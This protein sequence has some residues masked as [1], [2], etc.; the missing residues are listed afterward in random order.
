VCNQD[1]VFE[2]SV[3]VK[4]VQQNPQIKQQLQQVVNRELEED[5]VSLSVKRFI[6]AYGKPH[7][8]TFRVF[9]PSKIR[10]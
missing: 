10:S 3:F 5:F 9:T 8:S 7:N 1:A 2:N 4:L 6:S